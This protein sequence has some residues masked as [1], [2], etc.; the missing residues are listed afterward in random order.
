MP[1][2]TNLLGVNSGFFYVDAAG[3]GN[4]SS[5]TMTV[6]SAQPRFFQA[7]RLDDVSNCSAIADWAL[8]WGL[9]SYGDVVFALNPVLLLSLTKAPSNQP[10]RN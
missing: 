10:I 7:V 4:G 1:L 5:F 9:P 6:T 3:S 2:G 8:H